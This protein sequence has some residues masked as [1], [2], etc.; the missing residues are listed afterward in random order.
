[1]VPALKGLGVKTENIEQK[2]AVPVMYVLIFPGCIPAEQ[3]GLSIGHTGITN[4]PDDFFFGML[5]RVSLCN[6]GSYD[7][8]GRTNCL[9]SWNC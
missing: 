2:G 8:W 7:Q 4:D 3:C 6:K 9:L 1:M 5:S